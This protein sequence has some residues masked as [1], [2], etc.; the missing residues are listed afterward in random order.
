MEL[1]RG[2]RTIG[3]RRRVTRRNRSRGLST[4][5]TA[6]GRFDSM[7]VEKKGQGSLSHGSAMAYIIDGPADG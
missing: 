5:R 3:K 7:V 4:S 2:R 6:K 1:G